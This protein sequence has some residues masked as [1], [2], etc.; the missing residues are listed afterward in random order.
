LSLAFWDSG[1]IMAVLA[2]I[3]VLWIIMSGRNRALQVS[4]DVVSEKFEILRSTDRVRLSDFVRTTD[5]LVEQGRKVAFVE[6]RL[7]DVIARLDRL[8]SQIS[9]HTRAEQAKYRS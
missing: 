4:I 3:P 2:M 1:I 7:L 9:A 8:E 5:D 6:A